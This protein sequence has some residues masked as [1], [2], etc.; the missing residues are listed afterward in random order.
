[1]ISL[2]LANEGSRE[3]HTL[4]PS[5]DS[6]MPANRCSPAAVKP[7]MKSLALGVLLAMVACSGSPGS[8][9]IPTGGGAEPDRLI[10]ELAEAGSEAEPSEAF[11]TN[12]LGG[13]GHLI[14]VGAEEIRVYLFESTEEASAAAGRIDPD[15]P[16][17]LGDAMVAWAGNPRF[18]HRGSILVLYLGEDRDTENLLT[19][20]LGVPFA[21][22]SGRD[23]VEPPDPCTGL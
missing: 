10:A 12:P 14:C 7:T 5:P 8:D 9:A 18:W 4:I 16:S 23:P 3:R 6:N 2:I 17:N 19:E 13:K 11:A 20:V 21:R 22:G 15:D 1:M